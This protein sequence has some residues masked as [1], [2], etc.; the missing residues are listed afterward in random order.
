MSIARIFV[1]AYCCLAT[2]VWA[3]NVDSLTDVAQ[4]MEPSIEKVD[5]LCKYS[6]ELQISHN[7]IAKSFGENALFLAK[8]LDYTEGIIKAN[9]QIGQA[10]YRSSDY[11]KALPYFLASLELSETQQFT[12]WISNNYCSIGLI[13]NHRGEHDHSE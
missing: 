6:D 11:D 9:F 13:S 2:Q 5:Y 4:S 7:L 12:Y 3:Q 8:Q 1:L 10:Y